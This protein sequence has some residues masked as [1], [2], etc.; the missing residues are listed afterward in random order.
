M[1]LKELVEQIT[2]RRGKSP[3]ITAGAG[4]KRVLKMTTAERVVYEHLKGKGEHVAQQVR[5][6]FMLDGGGMY[7]PD[8][9]VFG[10]GPAP[11]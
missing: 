6:L 8:F 1:M 4:R 7:I 9:I 3:R 5:N 10:P 2:N 11:V